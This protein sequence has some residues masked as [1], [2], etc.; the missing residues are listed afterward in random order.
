MYSYSTL[1][2]WPSRAGD[3]LEVLRAFHEVE[4]SQPATKAAKNLLTDGLN[5]PRVVCA[6]KRPRTRDSK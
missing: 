5:R 3:L 4:A 6:A 1:F 2:D